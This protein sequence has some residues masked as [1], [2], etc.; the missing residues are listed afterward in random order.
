MAGTEQA[1]ERPGAS[2]D[3]GKAAREERREAAGGATVQARA[4]LDR[5]ERNLVHSAVRGRHGPPER[6]PDGPPAAGSPEAP[7]RV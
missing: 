3:S 5:W 4:Y 2:E 6:A 7:P 1:R